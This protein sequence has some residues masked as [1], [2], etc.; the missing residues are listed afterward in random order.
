M[1]RI[2]TF[3]AIA[4]LLAALHTSCTQLS[5]FPH[6]FSSDQAPSADATVLN[7]NGD[8]VIHMERKGGNQMLHCEL[9]GIPMDMEFDTGASITAIS[10]VEM[11]FLLKNG[12]LSPDDISEDGYKAQQ[13]D[14][15]AVQGYKLVIRELKVGGL[16]LHDV[17]AMAINTDKASVLFGQSAIR[18]L[19]P[20]TIDG[21]DLIVHRG[22]K[23]RHITSSEASQEPDV[24]VGDPEELP[25][26][27]AWS[28]CY[29]NDEFDEA[30]DIAESYQQSRPGS[31]EG[32]AMKGM[33]YFGK[34]EYAKAAQWLN[35]AMEANPSFKEPDEDEEFWAL[36]MEI[37]VQSLALCYRRLE[38]HDACI[39]LCQRVLRR[40]PDY[41]S[42]IDVMACAYGLR[43]ADGDCDEARR[44]SLELLNSN[45]DNELTSKCYFRLAW[46]YEREGKNPQAISL[47]HKSIAID[48]S[49][50][51]AYNNLSVLFYESDRFYS[52]E[53]KKHAARLGNKQARAFLKNLGID[54]DGE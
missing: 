46:L 20:F 6:L 3:W 22:T 48:P 36:D 24:E 28:L 30:M 15:S 8:I 34:E 18:M 50:S 38:D 49:N 32:Y 45:I 42:L 39:E 43:K 53:L 16:T 26:G 25:A 41:H 35:R 10:I 11:Q 21:D 54:P 37:A 44:I 4:A 5:S 33:V 40:H 13:A 31:W 17:P 29:W 7:E 52:L 27:A 14:G 1:K 23:S 2:T 9:N 47:Y 12:A 51:F 19:H